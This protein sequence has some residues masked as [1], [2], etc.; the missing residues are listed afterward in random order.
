MRIAA[1]VFFV[2]WHIEEAPV[3]RPL[4]SEKMVSYETKS[5]PLGGV[6]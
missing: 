6:W 5:A 4:I 2:A 3:A 1:Q